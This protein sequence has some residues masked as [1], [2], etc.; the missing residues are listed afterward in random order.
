MLAKNYFADIMG[1]NL[2]Y[3]LETYEWEG[4]NP[5]TDDGITVTG[6]WD[7]RKGIPNPEVYEPDARGV[8]ERKAHPRGIAFGFH[9]AGIMP[10]RNRINI[11]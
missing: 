11:S 3:A 6:F 2:E 9:R 10:R 1:I 8:Y 7:K 4:W 5:M